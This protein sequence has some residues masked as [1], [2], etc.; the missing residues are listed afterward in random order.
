MA[1]KF[2][3][4]GQMG[5]GWSRG[6][7]PV[8]LLGASLSLGACAGDGDEP[9]YVERPVEEIYDQ[10]YSLLKRRQYLQAGQ[11]FDE[12]E[13]QHPYSIWARRAML[14]SGFAYYQANKYE[15]AINASDRFIQLH[16]GN[17]DAPYAYYLKAI[18][19]YEQIQDVGRDQKKTLEALNAL[20]DIV[21]RYPNSEYARDARLKID[22]TRDHL[23][24]KEMDVGRY[25]LKREQEIA[26][27]NRFRNV[28]E[29]YQTTSHVPEA[30][31]R[32]VESYLSLG[33]DEEAQVAA[34]VLG[35]NFPGS[36]WYADSYQ[37]LQTK[38]LQPKEDE[39]S[40]ISRA[41]GRVL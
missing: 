12:V 5:R 18:C 37:L 27:I 41:F 16:P 38:D 9:E 28:I 40:W 31:H 30:L 13:R 23:A 29:T 19:F 32:L 10:A 35:Y 26:A 7:L 17:K 8:L 25:Y 33:L 36:E 20:Q 22:L 4:L 11:A 34:A 6:V 15:E 14:M 39:D 21:R 1:S 2:K 3:R 24:G